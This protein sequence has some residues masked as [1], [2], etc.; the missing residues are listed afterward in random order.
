[1]K[2]SIGRSAFHM[3]G[4]DGGAGLVL[5]GGF[6]MEIILQGVF[7]LQLRQSRS[8]WALNKISGS[9]LNPLR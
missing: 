7:I 3:R 8:P 5:T 1:M 2:Y 6:Q 4:I 9:T